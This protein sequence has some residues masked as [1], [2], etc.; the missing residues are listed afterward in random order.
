MKRHAE[1]LALLVGGPII[2]ANMTPASWLS[3]AYAG[4]LISP[5]FL[6][7]MTI[8]APSRAGTQILQREQTLCKL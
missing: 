6:S 4:V 8:I 5:L 7:R 2:G 3:R 1:N